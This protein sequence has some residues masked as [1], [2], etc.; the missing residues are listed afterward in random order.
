[1]YTKVESSY[2]T[3]EKIK[4]LDDASKLLGLYLL[5]TKYRNIVGL[6]FLP[7]VLATG[8]LKGWSEKKF[9][10]AL[11]KLLGVGFVKYD[12]VEQIVFIVNFL[13]PDYN[14]L[15][16]PNQVDAAM[17]KIKEL[18]STPLFTDLIAALRKYPKPFYE[19]LIKQLS[20]RLGKR[21]V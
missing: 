19:P 13:N 15:Q 7:A 17:K 3:D 14:P 4:P 16:N 5:T 10:T 1:M 6:Y 8:E 21:L 2:W 9:Q 12:P 11:D 20:E 18:P